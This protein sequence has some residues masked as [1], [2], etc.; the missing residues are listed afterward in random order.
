MH[1]TVHLACH[2]PARFSTTNDRQ[3]LHGAE[4]RLAMKQSVCGPLV[5]LRACHYM[6][7][8]SMRRMVCLPV[9]TPAAVWCSVL[10]ADAVLWS[11]P[12]RFQHSAALPTAR[13]NDNHRSPME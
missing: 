13:P 10:R 4:E 8:I 12:L 5:Q 2:T 9:P 1:P 11:S 7:R 3:R 6:L